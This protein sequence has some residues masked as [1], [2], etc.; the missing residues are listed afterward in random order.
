MKHL[1]DIGF[2]KASSDEWLS[3]VTLTMKTIP[4]V[5]RPAALCTLKHPEKRNNIAID[6]ASGRA[7]ALAKQA[8]G[9][10]P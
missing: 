1:L 7:W 4:W 5:P 3:E 8:V 2:L 6:S 9:G 10:G